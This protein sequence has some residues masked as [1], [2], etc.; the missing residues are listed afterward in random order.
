M[1]NRNCFNSFKPWWLWAKRRAPTRL[2]A[3]SSTSTSWSGRPLASFHISLHLNNRIWHFSIGPPP[4]RTG[5]F[6]II[7]LSGD[8]SF[9][10]RH[11]FQWLS[12]VDVLV[13]KATNHQGF[14]MACCHRFHPGRFLCSTIVFEVF[15]RSDVMHFDSRVR[16]TKL[17]GIR[18][19]PLN[20]LSTG[21]P[22][23]IGRVIEREF[24]PSSQRNASPSSD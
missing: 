14:A 4:N 8:A 13:A 22:V 7:R 6:R 12:V 2:P 20:D 19:K 23:G 17:T 5:Y 24:H 21:I 16:A 11:D 15:Q 9:E 10:V 18:E 1:L 3:S